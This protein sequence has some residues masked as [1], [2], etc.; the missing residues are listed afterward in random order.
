MLA[1]EEGI[2]IKALVSLKGMREELCKIIIGVQ[3]I[4]DGGND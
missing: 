2:L 1:V 4:M 3:E